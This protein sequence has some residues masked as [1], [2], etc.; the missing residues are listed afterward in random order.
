MGALSQEEINRDLFEE[1]Q[2]LKKENAKLTD[3]LT[4]KERSSIKKDIQIQGE[5]VGI[6]FSK[7]RD[8][9]NHALIN[10]YVEDDGMWIKGITLSSYWIDDCIDVLSRTKDH[11]ERDFEK[12]TDG[13][14]YQYKVD[15][16]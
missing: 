5:C 13:F 9:D 12:D 16:K 4:K 7:R 11:L 14:G 1:V 2:R 8:N 6:D 3:R 10:M 15:T